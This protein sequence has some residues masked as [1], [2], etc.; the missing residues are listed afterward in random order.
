MSTMITSPTRARS[1]DVNNSKQETPFSVLDRELQEAAEPKE[2][3]HPAVSEKLEMAHFGSGDLATWSVVTD[4][5]SVPP[6]EGCMTQL[7][8]GFLW[9]V[10]LQSPDPGGEASHLYDLSCIMCL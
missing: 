3:L 10:R 5:G 6:A 8:H 7:Q 2:A 4:P 9:L 1:V